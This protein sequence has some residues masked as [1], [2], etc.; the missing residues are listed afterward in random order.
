MPLW[1]KHGTRA[2]FHVKRWSLPPASAGSAGT[3]WPCHAAPLRERFQVYKLG[4][5]HCGL[6]N[7]STSF[8]VK[9]CAPSQPPTVDC[10]FFILDQ[11]PEEAACWRLHQDSKRAKTSLSPHHASTL[12]LRFRLVFA[13]SMLVHGGTLWAFKSGGSYCISI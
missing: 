1:T 6:M 5:V 2:E 13:L 10:F 4:Y 3:V 11:G 12:S 9:I 8:C 7:S